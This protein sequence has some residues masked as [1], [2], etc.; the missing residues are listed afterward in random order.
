MYGGAAEA[1]VRDANCL[2]ISASCLIYTQFLLST[3]T[4]ARGAN[5]AR[6]SNIKMISSA[7]RIC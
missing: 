5:A 6:F 1:L 3:Q 2:P 7:L 4:G